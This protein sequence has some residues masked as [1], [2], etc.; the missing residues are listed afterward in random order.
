MGDSDGWAVTRQGD[1]VLVKFK[2][3]MTG[4]DGA[5]SAKRAFELAGDD[6]VDLV[7]DLLELEHYEPQVRSDWQRIASPHKKQVNTV[8]VAA[9]KSLVRMGVQ[10]F[11]LF[12]GI[13]TKVVG[14]RAEMERC[15]L[16]LM[17]R[18]H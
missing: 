6:T 4:A 8:C 17:S 16:D 5:R 1:I 11:G 15:V 12:V 18:R 10:A 7:G 13:P 3:R 9:Q 2:G 14:T